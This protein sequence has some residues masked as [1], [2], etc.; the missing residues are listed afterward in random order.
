MLHDI[1]PTK[2]RLFRLNMPEISTPTCD[3]TDM[4]AEDNVPHALLQCPFNSQN[5]F[6]LRVVQTVLPHAQVSQLALLQ[7]PVEQDLKL[8]CIFPFVS[9]VAE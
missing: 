8:P 7:L 9:S 3:L 5:D 4:E 2:E 1:L 6:L